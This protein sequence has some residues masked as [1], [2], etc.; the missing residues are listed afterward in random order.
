MR[1]M[2]ALRNVLLLAVLAVLA[3]GAWLYWFANHPVAL[4]RTPFEFTVKN[5]ASVKS[6]S[7]RLAD[8]GLFFEGESFFNRI[9]L[10]GI[11]S[12]AVETSSRSH[13]AAALPPADYDIASQRWPMTAQYGFRSRI[14]IPR[15]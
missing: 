2:R 1:R 9:Y 14:A 6:V 13:L 12:S 10:A 7:R 15:R 3:L 5:G 11:P 8:E 4:T